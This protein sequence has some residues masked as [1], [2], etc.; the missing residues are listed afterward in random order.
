MKNAGSISCL[1][2]VLLVAA[3]PTL[4][5]TWKDRSGKF[6]VEAGFVSLKDGKVYLEKSDGSVVRVPVEQLSYA[7]YDFLRTLTSDTEVREFL[8]KHPLPSEYTV[9]HIPTV[10]CEP[11]SLAFSPDGRLLAGASDD[12]ILM[13]RL[14]RSPPTS[15]LL[16]NDDALEYLKFCTF[17]PDGKYL[18]THDP[19]REQ[20]GI[21]RVGEDGSLSKKNVFPSHE[22]KALCMTFSKDGRHVLSGD[23][24]GELR[25]WE[26]ETGKVVHSFVGYFKG[27]IEGC[28]INPKGTQALATDG[29][30]AILFDLTTG[31][32]IQ[33]MPLTKTY[34]YRTA[35][36]MDGRRVMA[37]YGG[38][39]HIWDTTA[40]TTIPSFKPEGKGPV[41]KL[42]LSNTG[43]YLLVGRTGT[44]DLW[45]V[46]ESKHIHSY[47]TSRGSYV[48]VAVFSADER[49]FATCSGAGDQSLQVFEIPS[50]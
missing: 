14:D 27:G 16:D 31:K 46:Q 32:G 26:F 1:S 42:C 22:R 36:S 12:G 47:P 2:L 24:R 18:V 7:D 6:A 5:R 23:E 20:V 49:F 9:F 39:I 35:L 41:W 50:E 15:S 34:V 3:A 40:A 37:E 4:A 48:K 21:W 28:F 13:I 10:E 43:R 30:F 38:S 17:T 33:K 44:V 11:E 45:D 25:Y 8:E 19:I 29:E